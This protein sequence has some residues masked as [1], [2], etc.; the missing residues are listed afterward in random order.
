MTSEDHL[1][2]NWFIFN[3]FESF[4]ITDFNFFGFC[5]LCVYFGYFSP[6][7]MVLINLNAVTKID[8]KMWELCMHLDYDH[9]A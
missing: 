4:V 2:L 5:F 1:V 8:C 3:V 6:K 9:F 7:K